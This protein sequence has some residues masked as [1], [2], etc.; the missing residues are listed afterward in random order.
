MTWFLFF[1]LLFSPY[2]RPGFHPARPVGPAYPIT[3][4]R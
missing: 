2:N 1:V 4:Q 3:V